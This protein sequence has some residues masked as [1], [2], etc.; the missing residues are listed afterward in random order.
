MKVIEMPPVH[1]VDHVGNNSNT[2][3]VV[4]STKYLNLIS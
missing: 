3:Y 1:A 2:I 4:E